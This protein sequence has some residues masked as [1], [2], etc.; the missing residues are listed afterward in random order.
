MPTTLS[1]SERSRGAHIVALF[2]V[3]VHAWL[4]NDFSE[5]ARTSAELE[6]LGIRVRITAARSLRGCSDGQ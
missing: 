4:T 6:Q 5:A 2:S 3:L 1:E